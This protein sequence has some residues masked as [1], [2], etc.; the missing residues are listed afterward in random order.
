VAAF[1][2]HGLAALSAVCGGV[3]FAATAGVMVW[4]LLALKSWARI[5]QI[6]LA[7]FGLPVCP[8][9]CASVAVLIYML[10][11]STRAHFSRGTMPEP[12]SK[13]GLFTGSVLACVVLGGLLAA[14]LTGLVVFLARGGALR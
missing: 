9:S 10:Q 11:G 3:L 12:S 14:A 1:F 5:L 2:L 8:F 4:G 6:V 13:E 7:V